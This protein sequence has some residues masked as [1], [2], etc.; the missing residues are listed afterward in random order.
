MSKAA[1]DC[2][3]RSTVG[4]W[5]TKRLNSSTK[6][7]P[8]VGVM[9]AAPSF[10]TALATTQILMFH[11]TTTRSAMEERTRTRRCISSR[12]RKSKT[13]MR[14]STPPN[15]TSSR[16]AS[17]VI[18]LSRQQLPRSSTIT[19]RRRRQRVWA[20]PS[21]ATCSRRLRRS[22]GLRA[23]PPP[24]LTHSSSTMTPIKLV[25]VPRHPPKRTTSRVTAT[26]H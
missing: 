4:S 13:L 11:S 7:W 2:A 6:R 25:W 24:G 21:R 19:R 10:A 5:R 17:R 12:R 14:S 3:T 9:E 22:S 18:I 15:F 16:S 20:I 26:N 8:V 1:C 23:P